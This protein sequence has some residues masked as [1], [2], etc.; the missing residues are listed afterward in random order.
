LT[1]GVEKG[2]TQSQGRL[3]SNGVSYRELTGDSVD[4]ALVL[5]LS[6]LTRVSHCLKAVLGAWDRLS[7]FDYVENAG[8][9]GPRSPRAAFPQSTET[10]NVGVETQ[11]PRANKKGEIIK[12]LGSHS[13]H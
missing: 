8:K 9:A 1:S 5:S 2:R 13:L 11:S 4:H 12:R 3:S 6:Y 7:G 10:L